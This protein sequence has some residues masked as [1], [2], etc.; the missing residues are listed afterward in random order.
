VP[1]RE[2]NEELIRRLYEA[3][4]AKDGDAMA[5]CYAPQARF[6]DPAFGQLEGAE[7]GAMWRMLT[8]RAAELEVEL[9]D[10]EAGEE[11]GAAHWVARYTFTATRRPVVN[12]VHADFWFAQGL[13]ADH[14]DEFDFRKWAR[15][16]FGPAGLVLGVPP[17]RYL[18]RARA[19]R[20]LRGF[21]ARERPAEDGSAES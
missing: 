5:A 10:Y 1:A 6:W 8:S 3:L 13:I 14:V 2:T 17:M 18:V 4:D 7:V 15:Q 12:D 16:A 20:D 11:G 21:L 9:R 19:R